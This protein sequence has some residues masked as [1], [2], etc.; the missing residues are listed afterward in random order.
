MMSDRTNK[1]SLLAVGASVS[2]ASLLA[3]WIL[4]RST[5][6]SN[7]LALPKDCDWLDLGSYSVLIAI[8]D[9]IVPELS[10]T[11][12]ID[13]DALLA[14]ITKLCPQLLADSDLA[15]SVAHLRSKETFLRLGGIR[16]NTH[17]NFCDSV[18]R[19]CTKDEKLQLYLVLKLLSTS[20][21]TLLLTG[22]PFA[23]QV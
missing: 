1:V 15:F 9:T 13:D 14:E 21:G 20:I 17:V 6:T 22:F 8:I 4:N 19:L 18:Q 16:A 2:A 3:W 12:A 23:F 11:E 5:L 10:E 7:I